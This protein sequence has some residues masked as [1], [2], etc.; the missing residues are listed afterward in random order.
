[1]QLFLIKFDCVYLNL[2][3]LV[4]IALCFSNLFGLPPPFQIQ[5]FSAPPPLP[6]GGAGAWRG[7]WCDHCSQYLISP[8]VVPAWPGLWCDHYSQYLISPWVAPAWRGPWCYHYSQYL[9]SPWM[10]QRRGE[11]RGAI[12]QDQQRPVETDQTQNIG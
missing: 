2:H 1:M 8:W 7:P 4:T 9:I 10:V 5:K 3:A 11:V 6:N 12:H